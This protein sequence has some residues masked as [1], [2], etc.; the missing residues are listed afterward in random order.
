MLIVKTEWIKVA[1]KLQNTMLFGFFLQDLH[2]KV[3]D[4]ILK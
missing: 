1:K 4:F 3:L 2:P